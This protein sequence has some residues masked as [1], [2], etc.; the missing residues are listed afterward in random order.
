MSPTR[1]FDALAF[2]R[3]ALA[4]TAAA[5][6]MVPALARANSALNVPVV[7]IAGEQSEPATV[8]DG[9]GGA[10]V[11]W[12][13]FRGGA[14][15]DIY[16]QRIGPDGVPLWGY[17]GV[18]ICTAPA[19]Q[20][21]PHIISDGAHGAIIGWSDYRNVNGDIY[22]Q[23]VDASGQPLWTPDGVPIC[24]DT[25]AQLGVEIVA[26]GAGGVIAVWEDF[27]ASGDGDLFAQR[28]AASGV[29]YWALNGVPVSQS[30][31][32]QTGPALTTDGAGGLIVIW[33]DQRTSIAGDLYG[34]RITGAGAMAWAVEGIPV[35]GATGGQY[36][37]QLVADGAGGAIASWSDERDAN[38][39]KIFAQRIGP[40]GAG[41][42]TTNGVAVGASA[43]YQ[44]FPVMVA[45]GAGGA[46]IAWEDSRSDTTVDIYAQ[47]LGSDGLARWAAGGVRLCDADG[48]EALPAIAA[49]G[50]G[51][52]IVAWQDQR[53]AADDIFAQRLDGDGARLW[54]AAG[55]A[56]SIAPGVQ[57]A[58][59]V[60]A[61]GLGGAL[62]AWYDARSA[63]WDIY[64]QHVDAAGSAGGNVGLSPA[65]ANGGFRLSA[66][67]PNPAFDRT[68]VAFRLADAARVTVEIFDAAGRSVRVIEPGLL[69]PGDH[70]VA[71][72]IGR[73]SAA[74]LEA[75]LYFV[76]IRAGT[77]SAVTRFIALP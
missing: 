19:F 15:A 6:M 77:R 51:G 30:A 65:P 2:P 49:D 63:D 68:R 48:Y 53:A 71:I 10:I 13:D 3:A 60:A 67:A 57:L 25:E 59:A 32:S 17:G 72:D 33:R 52:V 4:A 31:G 75:G 38:V 70:S 74:R 27:R 16:A 8:S 61:D 5:C 39:A 18:A 58:P 44:L 21:L 26:D 54:G 12:Q 43:A 24:D 37:V 22:V 41:V 62:F 9:S 34:Q 45:D 29:P 14:D 64:A 40:Q 55:T 23:R 56:V 69:D 1:H 11:V 47:R 20:T 7:V 73:A 76:R 36:D 46:V 28:I 66:P 50:A 42:W 35:C